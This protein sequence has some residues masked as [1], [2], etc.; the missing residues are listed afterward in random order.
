MYNCVYFKQ[1]IEVRS[2]FKMSQKKWNKKDFKI[3]VF[4]SAL[5]ATMMFGV[6]VGVET[7][8]DHQPGMVG[9]KKNVIFYMIVCIMINTICSFIA[10]N[11]WSERIGSCLV[12]LPLLIFFIG[13]Y[14]FIF[15]GI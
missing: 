11:K 3:S 10:L 8:L 7:F 2:Y 1:I 5:F 15:G 12:N 9:S 14:Y 6:A 4:I 13:V